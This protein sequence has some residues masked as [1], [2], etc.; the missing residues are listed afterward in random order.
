MAEAA[1][2]CGSSKVALNEEIEPSND[3]SKDATAA[4]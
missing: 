3:V 4:R 1:L 2:V